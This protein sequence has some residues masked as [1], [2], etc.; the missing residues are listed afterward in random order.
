MD[1]L[2]FT[3]GPAIITKADPS[4]INAGVYDHCDSPK[5]AKLEWAWDA[6]APRYDKIRYDKIR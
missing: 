3:F 4:R 2:L 1:R 5:L 6:Q